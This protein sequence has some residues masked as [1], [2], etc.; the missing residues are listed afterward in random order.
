MGAF[1]SIVARRNG[2]VTF[3]DL[4]TFINQKRFALKSEQYLDHILLACV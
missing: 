2:E 1:D 3:R 4:F